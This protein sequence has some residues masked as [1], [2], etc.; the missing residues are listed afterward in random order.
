[1]LASIR[2]Y[3]FRLRSLIEGEEGQDLIEYALVSAIIALGCITLLKTTST[4]LQSVFTFIN[5]KLA[6]V[7]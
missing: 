7:V 6:T 1:M 5:T 3:C 2:K 4:N